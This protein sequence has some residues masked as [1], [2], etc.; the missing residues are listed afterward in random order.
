ME[1]NIKPIKVGL[2]I[3]TVNHLIFLVLMYVPI[4]NCDNSPYGCS[5]EKGLSEMLLY[6]LTFGLIAIIEGIMLLGIAVSIMDKSILK[7]SQLQ[8]LVFLV[9]LIVSAYTLLDFYYA[10]V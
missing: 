2:R 8:V 6:L 3:A 4:N 9:T 7:V 5:P 10:H 1:L